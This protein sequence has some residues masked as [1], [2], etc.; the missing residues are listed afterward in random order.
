MVEIIASAH[1]ADPRRDGQA[2]LACVTGLQ[3]QG[4]MP[5]KDGHQSHIWQAYHLGIAN[6]SRRPTQPGHPSMGRQNE[7][8]Q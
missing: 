4:G 1:S 8:W 3:Y 5:A 2:E 7:H 6:Q